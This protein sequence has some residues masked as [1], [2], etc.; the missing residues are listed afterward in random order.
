MN[1]AGNLKQRVVLERP[2]EKKKSYEE[3][4]ENGKKI[5]AYTYKTYDK[6]YHVETEIF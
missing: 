5:W 2:K 3:R 1:K 4:W 6:F